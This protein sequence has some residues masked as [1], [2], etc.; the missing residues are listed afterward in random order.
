METRYLS[1]VT[2]GLTASMVVAMLPVMGCSWL[3]GP[4]G[5]FRDRSMDYKYAHVV[6]KTEVVT[7]MPARPME[8]NRKIPPVGTGHAFIPEDFQDVPRPHRVLKLAPN[9][10]AELHRDSGVDFLMVDYPLTKVEALMTQYWAEREIPVQ[11]LSAQLGSGLERAGKTFISD[12]RHAGELKKRGLVRRSFGALLG[13]FSSRDRWHRYKVYLLPVVR[14]SG[15][16]TRVII[17][18]QQVAS[19]Q[20]PDA[21]EWRFEGSAS[22]EHEQDEPQAQYRWNSVTKDDKWLSDEVMGFGQFVVDQATRRKEAEEEGADTPVETL[23]AKDGNGYPILHISQGFAEAWVSVGRAVK[24]AKLEVDDLNRSLAI[25]YI[26]V[27][28]DRRFADLV[29]AQVSAASEDEAEALE[30]ASQNR[31]L[32]ELKLN[33]TERGIQVSVQLDDETWAPIDMSEKLLAIIKQAI[34]A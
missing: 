20:R 14:T 11:A 32:L 29:A 8:E 27:E 21:S 23:L 19:K 31:A 6:E 7:G 4:E 25:F 5:H 1:G 2:K 18:H 30:Q 26:N 17:S 13:L 3:F 24:R 16:S 15:E 28:S 10:E 12:W 22:A 9:A 34:A 33:R